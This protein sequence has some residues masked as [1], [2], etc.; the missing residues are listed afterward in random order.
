MIP[1]PPSPAPPMTASN[2]VHPSHL[3]AAVDAAREAGKVMRRHLSRP[4]RVHTATA[5]DVKLELDVECQRII[6]RCLGRAFPDI[7]ILG[8]EGIDPVAEKAAVRWVV[9]PIDG[10]VNFSQGIP[11]ASVSIARQSRA[12]GAYRTD[13]GVILDPFQDEIWTAVRG[14]VARRNGRRIRV[15]GRE[16]LRDAVISLGFAKTDRELQRMFPAFARLA[17]RVRKIR[18]MGSAALA[19]AYVADGRFDG[20]V[21]YGIRLW[22]IAAGGLI[23]ECAGGVFEAEATGRGHRYRMQAHNGTVGRELSRVMDLPDDDA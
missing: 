23:V 20:Y 8:E 16:Q 15:S 13:L 19:L 14:G 21:E 5:H 17:R 18:I 10:T 22:D 4:K 11:H 1:R 3:A 12:D 7:P 9:D 2:K 6:T